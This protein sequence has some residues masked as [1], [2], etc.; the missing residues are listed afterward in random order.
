MVR[1]FLFRKSHKEP[2][3]SPQNNYLQPYMTS[4]PNALLLN[5]SKKE[6]TKQLKLS[7]EESPNS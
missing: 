4:S 6:P 2:H 3:L 7:T 5:K 1:H